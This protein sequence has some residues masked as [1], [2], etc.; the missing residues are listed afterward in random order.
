[1]RDGWKDMLKSKTLGPICI[2]CIIGVT[3]TFTPYKYELGWIGAG[4]ALIGFYFMF[5]D[6]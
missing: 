2:G 4:M 5:L 6:W 1:M 3:G